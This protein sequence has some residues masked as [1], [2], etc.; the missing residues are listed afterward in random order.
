MIR[1]DEFIDDMQIAFIILFINPFKWYGFL[2]IVLG[3]LL[4]AFVRTFYDIFLSRR[5][6]LAMR[7]IREKL[8]KLRL[9]K[10]PKK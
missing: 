10:K 6:S 7:K 3:A 8:K 1:F 4:V 2:A 5:I 9:W